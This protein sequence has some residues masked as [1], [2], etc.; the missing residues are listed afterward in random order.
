MKKPYKVLLRRCDKYDP[1]Q[2]ANIVKEGMEELG[3]KPFGKILMKPNVVVAHKEIFPYAFTRKEFLD[4][5][6]IAIKKQAE[7]GTEI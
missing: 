5:V 3:I 6:I 1:D 2:I 7:N 4:G